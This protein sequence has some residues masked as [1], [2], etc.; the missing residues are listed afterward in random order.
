[1]DSMTTVLSMVKYEVRDPETT[2][3][4]E[5]FGLDCLTFDVLVL[6][7]EARVRGKIIMDLTLIQ[8]GTSLITGRT[9]NNAN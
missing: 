7:G 3:R 6:G 4:S 9:G 8:T 1:M 2:L 5:C